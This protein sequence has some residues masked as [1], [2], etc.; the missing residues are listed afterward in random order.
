TQGTTTN[1]CGNNYDDDMNYSIFGTLK[2]YCINSD[3]TQSRM[4]IYNAPGNFQNPN[5][6]SGGGTN[7]IPYAFANGSLQWASNPTTETCGTVENR[8]STPVSSSVDAITNIP[9]QLTDTIAKL[10]EMVNTATGSINIKG[11]DSTLRLYV[12]QL[13]LYRFLRNPNNV[14]A[15][16]TQLQQFVAAKDTSSFGRMNQIAAALA[17]RDTAL[18]QQLLNTWNK[19]NRVDSNYAKFF[20]WTLQKGLGQPVNLTA[21]EALAQQCPQTDGNVVFLSQNLYNAITNEHR[22][23]TTVCDLKST[24]FPDNPTN[25]VSAPVGIN[26]T[27][28]IRQP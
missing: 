28:K 20:T 27:I 6:F 17:K 24:E 5:N 12:A 3:A 13:Q 9:P 7:F 23:F 14:A 18:V 22:I 11:T 15:K 26:K 16:S 10:Q 2:T 19:A 25:Y 4:Y 8:S 1:A 21:I